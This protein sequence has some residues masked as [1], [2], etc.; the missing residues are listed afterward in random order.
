M[1]YCIIALGF[2]FLCTGCK[3]LKIITHTDGGSNNYC[4]YKITD[5]KNTGTTHALKKGDMICIHCLGAFACGLNNKKWVYLYIGSNQFGQI[6]ISKDTGISYYIE[7][8]DIKAMCVSC[9]G[10]NTFEFYNR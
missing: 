9:P 8:A 5:V 1:K 7:T 6:N 10:S 4:V 2:F 3:Q